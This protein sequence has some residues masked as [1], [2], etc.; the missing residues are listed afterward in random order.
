MFVQDLTKEAHRRVVVEYLKAVM[1]K[2]IT[3][4]N[5]E[6]R[7]DGAERMIKEA[8]QFSFLFKKLSSVSSCGF[9]KK[10]CGSVLTRVLQRYY[11]RTFSHCDWS[12]QGEE[13]DWLCGSIAAIAEV[14]KLTDPT[15]LYLEVSTLV[16]KYPDIRSVQASIR[17]EQGL[18]SDVDTYRGK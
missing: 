3:F 5:A 16:S 17:L 13:T 2:R 8:D 14:F 11:P 12:L 1:Q 18:L 10:T 4:K 9:K 7:K 15:L 6:E